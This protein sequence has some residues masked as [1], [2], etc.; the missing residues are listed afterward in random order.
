MGQELLIKL[1]PQHALRSKQ[2]VGGGCR[3]GCAKLRFLEW[4]RNGALL[5]GL[6][7]NQADTQFSEAWTPF[8]FGDIGPKET[9]E[10]KSFCRTAIYHS[11]SEAQGMF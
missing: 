11:S 2:G 4:S 9:K 1:T 6:K 8:F 3:G 5:V 10:G 7:G